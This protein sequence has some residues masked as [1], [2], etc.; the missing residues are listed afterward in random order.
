MTIRWM[1]GFDLYNS[2]Y[3]GSSRYPSFPSG[4]VYATGRLG[5]GQCLD[6]SNGGIKWP[7]AGGSA[8]TDLSFGFGLKV[9][10]LNNQLAR[11]WNGGTV[12]AS[13]N[14]TSTGAIAVYRGDS[15]NLLG[16]SAAGLI[17]TNI[18]NYLEVEFVRNASTGVYKVYLNGVSVL[19]L[20]AQNT[21]SLDVD[22]VQLYWP[23]EFMVDDLYSTDTSTRIGEVRIDV[24]RPDADTAQKDWTASAGSD[25]Y[26]M[27]DDT[28]FGSTDFVSTITAGDKDY[29]TCSDLSFDPANIFAVQATTLAKKDDATTRTF[30]SN[31]KS[32]A[33]E[34][35]GET[36]GLSTS[37]SVYADIFETNPDG[38]VAW[39][40]TSV[41][42][43]QVGIEVV[44]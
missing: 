41:N 4:N 42:A 15:A 3:N 32:S 35:N 22:S 37:Y 23:Q 7:T 12:V 25:N 19:N 13:L 18:W 5:V 26:A 20:T 9:T 36:R 29:Y 38:S 10:T 14:I 6:V 34:A 1:D 31:I 8:I 2:T 40:Q 17:L 44:S 16:T 28:T 11:L 43:V 21:G 30:R 33:T 27:L 24:L 39:D